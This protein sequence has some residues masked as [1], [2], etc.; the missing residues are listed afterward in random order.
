[1]TALPLSDIHGRPEI[2]RLVHTFYDRIR[3][4]AMLGP[5]F[6]EVAK[7]DW[8]THLP[9]MVSFW[10]TVIFRTGDYTGSPLA[11]HVRLVS[12]TEMGRPQ[13]DHWL[14]LFRGTVDDL[15]AGEHAD[16]IKNC[17]ADMANV[18]HAKINAMPD[19]AADPSRLTEEQRARYAAYR[20]RATT[21]P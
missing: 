18:I 11:A 21:P 14:A 12:L 1:M 19:P 3:T 9:R 17:A 16:H 7:T 4:D 2:E 13:F 8:S 20:A 6:N 15:F 10:E 5:I